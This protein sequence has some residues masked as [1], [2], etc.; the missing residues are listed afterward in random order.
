MNVLFFSRGRGKGHAIPDMA[1]VNALDELDHNVTCQFVSYGTG[2]VT[3]AEFGHRVCDLQLPDENPFL[4][5]VVRSSNLIVKN[6]PDVIVAHEEFAAILAGKIHNVPSIFI[7]DWFHNEKYLWMQALEFSKAVLFLGT[8]G[9][10]DEPSYL[11]GKIDYV[12]SFVRDFTYGRKDKQ[13]ARTELNVLQDSLLIS[14]LPGAW[15]TE[16]RAPISELMLSAFES[17]ENSDK[18]LF[19][20]AGQDF[21]QLSEMTSDFDNV[22]I[23]KSLWPIEQLMVASDL[24][25]TK[26]NRVTIMEAAALGIPSI[27]LSHG[28]NQ[29]ED[30]IVPR[31]KTNLPLRVRGIDGTYLRMCIRDLLKTSSE[32]PR[33]AATISSVQI[34]KALLHR[35][36]AA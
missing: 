32:Q 27:S 1:I 25:I 31:I 5:T 2:A 22:V 10:F 13:R 30:F 4:E 11:R 24:I 17:L 19:W 33:P 21:D 7:T 23:L 35:I 36:R 12:G 9:V 6:L 8:Q 29:V 15:A 14:V 34:A 20:V 28:L 18:K 3:L 26:G 16:Q